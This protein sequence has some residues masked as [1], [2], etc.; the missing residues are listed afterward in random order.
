MLTGFS[1]SAWYQPLPD[2]RAAPL[3]RLTG[4]QGAGRRPL[5]LR[6]A[7]NTVGCRK[8]E[9]RSGGLNSLRDSN[10]TQRVWF[11]DLVGMRR[12]TAVPRLECG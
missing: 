7:D 8:V 9:R 12:V 10:R 4:N 6:R 2:R 3:S 1:S 11:G 5:A